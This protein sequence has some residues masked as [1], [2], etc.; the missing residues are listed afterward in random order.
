MSKVMF[1]IVSIFAFSYCCQRVEKRGG[2]SLETDASCCVDGTI[3]VN[4]RTGCGVTNGG[5]SDPSSCRVGILTTPE[6]ATWFR[7]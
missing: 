5:G 7:V 1:V 2:L 6:F 3:V 4:A